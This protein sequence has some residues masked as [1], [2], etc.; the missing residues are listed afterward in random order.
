MVKPEQIPDEALDAAIAA[1]L[2]ADDYY[3]YREHMRSIIAE[4]INAWPGVVVFEDEISLPMP[5]ERAD[6]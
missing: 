4:A 6:G 1:M 3:I 5:M 2:A